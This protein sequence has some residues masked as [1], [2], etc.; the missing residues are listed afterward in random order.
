MTQTAIPVEA[1]AL[2]CG[3][4]WLTIRR[5]VA[6][7]ALPPADVAINR[8]DRGWSLSALTAHDPALAERVKRVMDVVGE[9]V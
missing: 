3:A 6:A 2:S 7:G 4:S 9:V 1:I 5:R 8:R